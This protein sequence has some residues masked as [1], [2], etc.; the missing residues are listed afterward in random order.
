[1]TGRMRI[2]LV[3]GNSSHPQTVHMAALAR[4]FYGDL[5]EVE[6]MTSEAAP[7]YVLTRADCAIA[8]GELLRVVE[9]RLGDRDRPAID[10]ICIACFGEPGLKEVR[11]ISP[12]PVVGMLESSVLTALQIGNRFGI[13]TPGAQWPTMLMELLQAW[14]LAGRCCGIS[15]VSGRV[16]DD[17]PATR[18]ESLDS[19]ARDHLR[20]HPSDVLIVGGGALAGRAADIAPI[21]GV[22]V[23]D[24]FI[25][26]L[27][28]LR[29]LIEIRR[30]GMVN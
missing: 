22:T 24:S 8:A 15:Q 14:S 26:T 6:E 19:E 12:V 5:V 3:N 18:A 10:G 16:L 20:T 1:M 11:E 17:D 13:L 25:V 2:L 23:L 21:D 9:A 27:G 7:R 4:G 30:H 29:T 28:Q